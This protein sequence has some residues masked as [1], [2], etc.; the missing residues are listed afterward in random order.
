MGDS[1]VLSLD[2]PL[3]GDGKGTYRVHIVGNSGSGKSTLAREL[4]AILNVR[5]ISLDTMF[6]RPG[7]KQ[8]PADEFRTSVRAALDQDP[9]G[10]AVDGMFFGFLGNM[11]P[12]KATDVI[13]LDPPLLLY[14]PRLCWR[15]FLRL[16]GFVPPCTTGCEESLWDVFFSRESIIWWTLGAHGRVRKREAERYRVDGVH[17]GGKC[18][19]LGG[20]GGELEAWKQAV[21]GMAQAGRVANTP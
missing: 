3:R 2:P 21:R 13:W 15:T 8:S 6:W 5:Y 7:W 20:W 10:W 16:L 12:D 11:V 17:V 19:R 1:N 9:R 14:F 18:R 4:S